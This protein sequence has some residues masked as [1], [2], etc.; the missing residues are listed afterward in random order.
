MFYERRAA[1]LHSQQ[2]A[3]LSVSKLQVAKRC[4]VKI[5]T[6]CNSGICGTCMTDLED[7]NGKG[8]RPGFQVV[9]A[10]VTPVSTSAGTTVVLA[11]VIKLVAEAFFTGRLLLTILHMPRLEFLAK[12]SHWGG[13]LR[14]ERETLIGRLV[15]GRT[16]AQ[17]VGLNVVF[18]GEW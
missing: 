8:Y 7:A 5:A 11:Q 18:C 16:R 4:G 3:S 14:E 15:W 9:K 2:H 12:S 1:D 17:A 6:A 13:G 10:C